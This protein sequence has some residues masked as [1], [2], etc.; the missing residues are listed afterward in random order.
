MNEISSPPPLRLVSLSKAYRRQNDAARAANDVDRLIILDKADF[1]LN[2][3]ELVGLVAP[4]GSGKSTL[5]HMA[6]LLDSPDAGEIYIGDQAAH[7]LPDD[8]RT[9]LRRHKIGFVYQFHH[10]LPEFTALENLVI[11]QLFA[12][13]AK[14]PAE[15]RAH[16]L[17]QKLG[18]TERAHHRPA[19]LS[20]GEQQRIAVA[21]ALVNS[22]LV[23][24]ADEPS[25]NLDRETGLNLME[26]L[27]KLI[28][29]TQQ[30]ALI[31]TH[32]LDHAKMMDRCVTLQGGKIMPLAV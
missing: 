11:P 31:A 25:G 1:A 24:L 9:A 6:G 15:Q 18:L 28:R 20:G 21:R 5:L 32:N 12:G 23:I 29:G 7:N 14:I 16:D 19:R 26:L 3:G 22:P 10:L 17:L 27:I 8:Q 2:Q 4:S 13:V 30:A